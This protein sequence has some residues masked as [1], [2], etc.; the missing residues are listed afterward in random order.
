MGVRIVLRAGFDSFSLYG[1][2]AID[3]ALALS[4]AGADVVPLPTSILPGLPR[5]FTMLLE[6]NPA[7]PK[8]LLLQ[9]G[10]PQQMTDLPSEFENLPRVAYS[11]WA[12]PVLEAVDFPGWRPTDAAPR[13]L[14][15]WDAV[16][17]T[18][19]NDVNVLEP[20]VDPETP[21]WLAPLGVWGDQLPVARRQGAEGGLRVLAVGRETPWDLI[22]V[23]YRLLA[24]NPSL[25]AVL[26][27]ST[28]WDEDAIERLAQIRNR[29]I[30]AAPTDSIRIAHHGL[31]R[32]AL[33]R[34]YTEQDLLI[35]PSAEEW[36]DRPAMEFMAT[37]GTVMSTRCS[38]HEN[39]LFPGCVIEI[40]A[41]ET[42]VDGVKTWTADK[43]AMAQ[44]LKAAM[45]DPFNVRRTGE[46]AARVVRSALSWESVGEATLRMLEKVR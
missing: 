35:M 3:L 14:S 32:E 44:A 24:E 22:E 15:G 26:T 40:A 30:G 12:R 37:G 21:V 4:R 33:M 13:P 11:R 1:S 19:R 6:K 45:A 25:P 9:F 17:G 20:F 23:W 10:P 27:L 29:A 43:A 46:N 16:I 2:D 41:E 7:G 39:W 28:P 31:P 42:E 38:G 34:L 5:Q 18:S 36:T 8:D